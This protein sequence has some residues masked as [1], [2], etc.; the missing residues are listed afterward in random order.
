MKAIYTIILFSIITCTASAQYSVSTSAPLSKADLAVM[1]NTSSPNTKLTVMIGDQLNTSDF[2]VG[3]TDNPADADVIITDDASKSDLA[4]VKARLSDANFTVKYGERIINPDVRILLVESGSVDILVYSDSENFDMEALIL[5]LLPIIN[6]QLDYVFDVI[7]Y[8][9][10][11]G[12]PP[13][14]EQEEEVVLQPVK[15]TGLN[16]AHWIAKIDGGYIQLEDN[17][18]F[19]VY[20]E[21]R[22]IS[23]L[24]KA[25]NDVIVTPTEIVGHYYITKD[26]GIYKEAE[27][28]R[29][30]CIKG[31]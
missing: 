30:I 21:D 25:R 11:E 10:P 1:I 13:T 3:F 20:D 6:A 12:G 8:W 29:A 19:Y 26:N 4:I 17:A 27:S 14:Q 16:M 28:L 7:P 23:D 22:Y 18:V 5:G 15:Y 31:L 24:W 9:G 2:S